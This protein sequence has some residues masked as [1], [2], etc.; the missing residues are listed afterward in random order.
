MILL[1]FA[2]ILLTVFGNSEEQQELYEL[3][4]ELKM[5]VW[6]QHRDSLGEMLEMIGQ[7]M[8]VSCMAN[9]FQTSEWKP[10]GVC[11]V[12]TVPSGG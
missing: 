11:W 7:E 6:Q 3:I 4:A 1:L 9:Q 10:G 2:S 12:K 8:A 5:A